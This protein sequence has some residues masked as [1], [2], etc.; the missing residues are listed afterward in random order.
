LCG[1][2]DVVKCSIDKLF[3]LSV[4]ELTGTYFKSQLSSKWEG[5]GASHDEQYAYYQQKNNDSRDKNQ[6]L[7]EIKS[8]SEYERHNITYSYE[9][10]WTR[11]INSRYTI[12]TTLFY[13]ISENGEEHSSAP[14]YLAGVVP[15]FAL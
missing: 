12:P 10:W 15:A 1:A 14:N 7:A 9:S 4:V 5:T 11:S 3:L 2:R 6:G 13:A 8:Q